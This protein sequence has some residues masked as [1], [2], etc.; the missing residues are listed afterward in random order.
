M[1]NQATHGIDAEN[2]GVPGSRFQSADGLFNDGRNERREFFTSLAGHPFG[3]RGTGGDRGGTAARQKTRLQH[4]ALREARRQPQHVAA[5]RVGD[6][7]L[8]G[9]RRQLAGIAGVLKMAEQT[10]AMHSCFNYR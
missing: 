3:Q 4:A 1:H 7:H 6:V 10:L 8:D 5:G 2:G 9:G